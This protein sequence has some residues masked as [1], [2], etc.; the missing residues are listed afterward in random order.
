MPF[1]WLCCLVTMQRSSD[2]LS[3][4]QATIF[5]Y[6]VR[7]PYLFSCLFVRIRLQSSDLIQLWI[8]L[9][10]LWLFWSNNQAT[11]LWSFKYISGNHLLIFVR[12]PYL[13]SCLFIR[14]RL[15]SSDLI[16]TLS[17]AV[18]PL[19]LLSDNQATVLWSFKYVSG[20][21]PLIFLYGFLIFFSCLLCKNQAT[22][23]WSYIYTRISAVDSSVQYCNPGVLP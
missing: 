12:Y 13:F 20:N 3:T 5:W 16:Q 9:S 21:H 14:I 8:R 6:F 11:V 10:F 23:L 19:T 15:Q 7:Y 1:L 2:L 22:I 17:Q 4:Y 18:F